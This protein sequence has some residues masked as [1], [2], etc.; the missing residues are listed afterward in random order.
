M[1]PWVA[2]RRR[3]RRRSAAGRWPVPPCGH[4]YSNFVS[5]SALKRCRALRFFSPPGGKM[6]MQRRGPAAMTPHAAADGEMAFFKN[7]HNSQKPPPLQTKSAWRPGGGRA[8]RSYD[9]RILF[10]NL[11]EKARKSKKNIEFKIVKKLFAHLDLLRILKKISDWKLS[12]F[13]GG[14]RVL[15]SKSIKIQ[16]VEKC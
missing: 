3:Y 14:W 16:T 2:E 8:G 13:K 12:V 11:K 10:L 6:K 9:V 7:I 5:K 4:F 1:L 15:R